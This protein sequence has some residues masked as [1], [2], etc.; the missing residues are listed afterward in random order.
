M[1][2]TPGQI[3]SVQCRA[4]L[5]EIQ[6]EF[7][8][9]LFRE[10]ATAI[11]RSRLQVDPAERQKRK[12]FTSAIYNRLY[13]R[14]RGICPICNL[15]MAKPNNFPGGLEVDHVN[16]NEPDFNGINNLQLTHEKCNRQKGAKSIQ[17]QSKANGKTFAEIVFIPVTEDGEHSDGFY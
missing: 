2:D 1:T 3:R 6:T 14:Q 17:E 8:Y 13:R 7:G 15:A 10:Q 16:P 11:V 5:L 4:K 9:S 12:H